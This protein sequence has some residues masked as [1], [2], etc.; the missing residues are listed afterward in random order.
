M[1]RPGAGPLWT[2]LDDSPELSLPAGS[3]PRPRAVAPSAATTG[4]QG[5]G[6]RRQ[7][8]VA[9][10]TTHR[11]VRPARPACH[12]RDRADHQPHPLALHAVRRGHVCQLGMVAATRAA[13]QLHLQLR[14]SAAR[15]DA[16]L[17]WTEA[18]G[19]LGPVV[20]SIDHARE[21]MALV[22][23]ASCSLLYILARRLG[24]SWPA[25]AAAVLAMA[26]TPAWRFLPSRGAA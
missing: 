7:L 24:F 20:F 8:V 13:G 4:T 25:A 5:R 18:Q 12:R 11:P 3:G 23:L 9:A 22:F 16:D 6:A 1:P 19:L 17:L 26:L 15:L 10:R 14:A 21:L 2:R